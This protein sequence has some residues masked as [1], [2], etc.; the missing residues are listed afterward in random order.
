MVFQLFDKYLKESKKPLKSF[1]MLTVMKA[2]L[3]DRIEIIETV[4]N[5][6]RMK[7]YDPESFM[8]V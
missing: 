8:M 1:V 2:W 6:E 3:I 4:S 7:I 5:L